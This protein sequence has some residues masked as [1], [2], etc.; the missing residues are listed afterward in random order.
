MT[1]IER[2]DFYRKRTVSAG[3]KLLLLAAVVLGLLIRSC[4]YQKKD[5]YYLISDIEI[6][7]EVQ[8]SVDIL[9]TVANQTRLEKDEQVIIRVYTSRGDE[10]VSRITTIELLPL[11]KRRYRKVMSNWNR[12]LAPDEVIESATVEIFKPSIFN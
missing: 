9:F 3:V 11:T 2:P 8:G 4:W 5:N 10:L 6:V 12:T 1:H 7:G